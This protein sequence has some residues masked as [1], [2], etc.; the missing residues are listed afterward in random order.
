MDKVQNKPNSSVQH[1]PSSESF[2]VY[3]FIA[4]KATKNLWAP[5]SLCAV[6]CIVIYKWCRVFTFFNYGKHKIICLPSLHS[7]NELLSTS[8][9][10]S[11]MIAESDCV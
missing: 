11:Q 2:Q 6:C 1:T 10:K 9:L 3:Q 8:R 4:L 7:S 5:L